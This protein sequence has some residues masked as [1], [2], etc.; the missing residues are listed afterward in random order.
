MKK[1]R[2]NG[3]KSE[4]LEIINHSSQHGPTLS[5]REYGVSLTSINKWI[6]AFEMHGEGG[7]ES[8]HKITHDLSSQEVKKLRRENEQLKQ[9][10]AEKE[11]RLRIQEDLLKKNPRGKNLSR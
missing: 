4:K 6:T 3:S 11:L 5:S 9:I 2:R 1:H 7:L 8:R 10:I